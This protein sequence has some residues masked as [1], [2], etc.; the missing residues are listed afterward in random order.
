MIYYLVLGILAAGFVLASIDFFLAPEQ[1]EPQASLPDV[2]GDF[3]EDEATRIIALKG[4]FTELEERIEPNTYG[5]EY[6]STC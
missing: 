1:D 2:L 5:A 3:T 4:C 6:D